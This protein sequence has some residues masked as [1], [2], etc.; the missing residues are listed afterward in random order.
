MCGNTVIELNR[1]NARLLFTKA[2]IQCVLIVSITLSVHTNLPDIQGKNYIMNARGMDSSGFKKF[3][4]I[5][6]AHIHIYH[7]YL[8][9]S[10]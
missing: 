1:R 10:K 4:L 7:S 6:T 2:G 3:N 8:I 5:N 9:L